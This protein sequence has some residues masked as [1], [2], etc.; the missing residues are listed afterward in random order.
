MSKP[1]QKEVE[2]LKVLGYINPTT[3]TPTN[4]SVIRK[5]DGAGIP[6]GVIKNFANKYKYKDVPHNPPKNNPNAETKE[7]LVNRFI[8]AYNKKHAN[9]KPNSNIL[10]TKMSGKLKITKDPERFNYM[11]YEPEEISESAIE[12]IMLGEKSRSSNKWITKDHPYFNTKTEY[13]QRMINPN[14]AAYRASKTGGKAYIG[15][16]NDDGVGDVVVTNKHGVV[17]YINGHSRHETEHP[18]M[19]EYFASP[20][21]NKLDHKTPK[22]NEISVFNRK[23]YKEWIDTVPDITKRA[24]NEVLRKAGISGYKVKDEKV[25][26][27]LKNNTSI[28]YDNIIEGF[29]KEFSAD[30]VKEI[31]KQLSKATFSNRIVNAILI[32]LSGLDKEKIN[33]NDLEFYLKKT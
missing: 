18:M 12:N 30:E 32:A 7:H 1:T 17:K 23:N 27:L 11:N 29:K 33:N 8:K 13:D 4:R 19:M 31:K 26:N 14:Y 3:I 6:L 16:F 28:I 20:A 2:Y 10:E 25:T 9:P 5:L 21:Y 24:A 15:D 22:G